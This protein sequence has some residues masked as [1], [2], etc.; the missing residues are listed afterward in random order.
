[1]ITSKQQPVKNWDRFKQSRRRVNLEVTICDFKMKQT[2]S[3]I[4]GAVTMAKDLA[5]FPPEQIEQSMLL[6]RGHK[7]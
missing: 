1:V 7:D 6:I 5:L 4:F 3:L 2:I